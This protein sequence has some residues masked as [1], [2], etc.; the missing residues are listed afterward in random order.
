METLGVNTLEIPVYWEQFEPEPGRYDTSV[1]DTILTEARARGLRL[2]LLWFATW[3]NGSNHYMPEWMKLRPETYPNIVG[4]AGEPID[5]P[6]PHSEATLEADKRAFVAFMRHLEEA[7]P[8]HTVLMVQVENEPGS[9]DAVRD[10]SPTAQALFE[11]PVPAKALAAMGVPVSSGGSWTKAFGRNADEYFQV[12]HVARFI[13]EVAAAGKAVYPIPMYVNGA[14][15]DPVDPGWPPRYEVGG[16]NDNVFALWKAAAPAVD[17]LAPDIYIADTGKYLK[18]LD[19]YSRPDNALLVPE[20]I[21]FGALT[22]FLFAALGRGAIG[23]APFG[24]D[25]TQRRIGRDGTPPSREEAYGDSALNYRM[26]APMARQIARWSF[27]GRVKTAVQ[28]TV[29]PAADGGDS[30]DRVHY[31]TDETLHFDGWDADVAFGTFRRMARSRPQGGSPDGR[32]LVAELGEGRYVTAGYHCRVMFRPTGPR[33]GR[34]WQYLK[35][36]EG[37][38][39]G[40]EFEASRILNGDETDW[41]LVFGEPTV[42]RV[43]LYSR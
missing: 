9:W 21:G 35:V 40:D 19:L 13:G 37:R 2:V 34:P 8:D 38:F 11:G 27:E 23:Y 28:M 43:S 10:H 17:I 14:I 29:D 26:L 36:E 31:V 39:V 1:V 33:E 16:P 15:R 6:S 42:L 41:G 3:K 18:V 25:D 24:M 4:P 20:T 5:S 30:V 32:I 7:D 12:W 22:R